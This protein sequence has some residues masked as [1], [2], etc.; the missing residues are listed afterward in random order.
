MK[1][2]VFKEEGGRAFDL[3]RLRRDLAEVSDS[4][5]LEKL[6]KLFPD[7]GTHMALARDAQGRISGLLTLEDIMEELIG[8]IHD[9]F[10]LPDAWSLMD[11]LVPSTVSV[12]LAALDRQDVI[13]DGKN[14]V[15]YFARQT[16]PV[17]PIRHNRLGAVFAPSDMQHDDL[18][19]HVAAGS[20]AEMAGIRN[21]DLLLKIDAIDVTKWRTDPAV[22]VSSKWQQPAGTTM[23]LT[24]K[25][26]EKEFTARVTLRD[27][28]GPGLDPTANLNPVSP[29]PGK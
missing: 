29:R 2:L 26:D 6:L 22:H 5:P 19:A 3:R 18:V 8:E 10:D 9:E 28:L 11:V 7:K 16:T 27:I 4:D 24:L 12:G 15:V 21:G 13:I 20:P 14:G 23:N 17:R 1:D 25:R